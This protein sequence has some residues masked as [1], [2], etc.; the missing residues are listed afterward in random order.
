MF[1]AVKLSSA[2]VVSPRYF[3]RALRCVLPTEPRR[4]GPS[5]PG[6][7]PGAGPRNTAVQRRRR[8]NRASVQPHRRPGPSGAQ[9]GLPA[10]SPG[11]P[12][13]QR[14]GWDPVSDGAEA[15]GRA[16]R[17]VGSQTSASCVPANGLS[18]RTGRPPSLSCPLL[19]EAGVCGCGVLQPR[20]REHD[21]PAGGGGSGGPRKC[22]CHSGV[23]SVTQAGKLPGPRGIASEGPLLCRHHGS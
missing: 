14:A 10:G 17:G 6:R 1:C 2:S 22:G 4:R 16:V 19:S 15:R 20:D 21:P 12:Q 18:K 23:P 5:G 3:C 13:S 11:R 9:R 8:R 7:R